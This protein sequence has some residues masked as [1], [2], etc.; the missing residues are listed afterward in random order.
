MSPNDP[1]NPEAIQLT[2]YQYNALLLEPP[3]HAEP[4]K[5]ADLTH[6]QTLNEIMRQF[7]EGLITFDEAFEQLKTIGVLF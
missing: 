7:D 3:E 6:Q 5:D 4:V 1:D 2:R